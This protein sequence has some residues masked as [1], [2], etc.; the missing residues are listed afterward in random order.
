M[1]N[2]KLLF[3]ILVTILLTGC[4]LTDNNSNSLRQNEGQQQINQK[5]CTLDDCLAVSNLEAY[6][7]AKLNQDV[8][9]ALLKAL[10]DE[11]KAYAT[12]D[13]VIDKFGAVR[14]F[15]MI[16]RAEEQ[17]AASLKSLFDKYGLEI[18]SNSYIKNIKTPDSLVLSCQS[19]VE[20]EIANYKLYEELLEVAKEYPDIVSVF[21][22]LMN[23]SKFKHLPAFENCAE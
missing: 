20:A 14:P 6:P 11:Y 8:Q 9:D 19:G 3:I 13:A 18:P 5:N 2:L 12:Y 21:T 10:D 7:V 4:S 1:H 15:I 23:A 17:H 22:N 16:I